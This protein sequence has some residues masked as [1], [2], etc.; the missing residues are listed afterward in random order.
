MSFFI[1]HRI[2]KREDQEANLSP[3][4]KSDISKTVDP[5]EDDKNVSV[6]HT[7]GGLICSHILFIDEL[8]QKYRNE[9][10]YLIVLKYFKNKI[11]RSFS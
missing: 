6:S 3:N 9:F 7:V 11:F 4:Q 8:N 10:S 2:S 5:S 1:V